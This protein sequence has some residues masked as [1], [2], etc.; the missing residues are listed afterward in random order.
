[1]LKIAIVLVALTGA[2]CQQGPEIYRHQDGGVRSRLVTTCSREYGRGAQRVC[3]C[4]VDRYLGDY[5]QRKHLVR[6][7]ASWVSQARRTCG[8]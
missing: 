6:P 7:S 1:M 2:G 5:P 4:V 8:A 3:G